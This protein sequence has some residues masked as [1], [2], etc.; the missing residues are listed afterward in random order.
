MSSQ[1][2]ARQE[3][4]EAWLAAGGTVLGASERAARSLMADFHA[5][6]LAQGRTAWKTPAIFSWESW[7]RD[8][9]QKRNAA[10]ALLL[11]PLQ[12]QSLW[13]RVIQ[14]TR[15]DLLHPSRLAEAAMRAYRLLGAYAP[16][17]LRASA[18]LG[19]AGDAAVFSGWV[20]DFEGR[21]RREGLASASRL[22]LELT[23]ALRS[24]A[25]GTE[26]APLLLVGFDRVLGTQQ[27]LLTSWG[28]W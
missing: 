4:V 12:E 28:A 18:R 15:R 21:C 3:R 8:E 24:E 16:E 17:A 19:W 20:E 7:L 5:A 2:A 13:L 23:E 10:G 26:R 11:N 9:W 22:V 27:A 25:D 14:R 6:Q 1:R